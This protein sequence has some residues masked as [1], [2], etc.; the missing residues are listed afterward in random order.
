MISLREHVSLFGEAVRRNIVLFKFH[1]D[2]SYD[3]QRSEP[4][5]YVVAGFF[6]DDIT[7]GNVESRWNAI[8]NDEHFRVAR[9]H[10]SHLNAKTYEYDGWDDVKKIDYSRQILKVV[11]DQRRRL[12]AYMCTIHADEYR[13]IISE[14]GREKLGHPYLVCFKTCIALIAKELDGGG[15]PSEDKIAVYLDRNPFD[16]EAEALFYEL[17]DDPGFPY[18]SRLHSCTRAVMDELTVL[19]TGDLIAY[20]GFRWNHDRRLLADANTR[21]VMKAMQDHNGMTERYYGTKTLTE[22]K[23]RY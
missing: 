3:S 10:A 9:F 23:S 17:K 18:S 11:T 7:W 4:R 20:E 6:G 21:V 16:K 5:T 2:E 1:C 13:R 19:Q 12:H 14:H 8:N 22:L 15:F